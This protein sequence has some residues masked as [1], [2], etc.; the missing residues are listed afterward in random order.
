M[1]LAWSFVWITGAKIDFGLKELAHNLRKLARAWAKSS[2]FDN[3]FL[4]EQPNN[5]IRTLI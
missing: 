3:F 2:F 1:M 5:F 4:Q